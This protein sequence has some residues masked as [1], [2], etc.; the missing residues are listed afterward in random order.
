[1]SKAKYNLAEP[2]AD[3]ARQRVADLLARHPLYPEIDLGILDTVR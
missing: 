3:G 2:V 1:V